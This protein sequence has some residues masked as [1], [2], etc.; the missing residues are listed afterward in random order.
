MQWHG[1]DPDSTTTLIFLH[2]GL[3]SV[4]LWRD[5]PAC[6][7]EATDTA[8]LVYSRFGYGH[9]A[10]CRLPRPLTY[11]HDE[12]LIHLPALIAATGI[13]DHIVVGHSDGGSIALIYAAAAA[14]PG[15]HGMAL[16]AAHVFNEDLNV[17]AIA[18]ARVA[19]DEGNLRQ[20]LV[21]HHGD[22]T[23]YAF[24]GWCN[25]W[26][27]PGFSALEYRGIFAFGHDAAL[28]HAGPGRRI[29]HHGTGPRDRSANRRPGRKSSRCP[30][31]ATARIA[32]PPMRPWPR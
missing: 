19:Y 26:L 25:A 32:T 13:K 16:M 28:D 29:R 12:G 24:N 1:P 4:S 2:E 10:P 27:D 20:R 23:D 18:A 7:A 9:S 15:L 30:I 6:L 14:R 22:N 5:F 21:R 8:A 17:K 31:A 3:G 11:M